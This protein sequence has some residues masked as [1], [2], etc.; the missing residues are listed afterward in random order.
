MGVVL[1]SNTA[2]STSPPTVALICDVG[3]G[4]GR[5]IIR[6]ATRFANLRRKWALRMDLLSRSMARALPECDGAIIAGDDQGKFEF[7][8]SR[9]KHVVRVSSVGDPSVCPIVT[10]DNAA[11]GRLA[12]EHLLGLGLNHYAYLGWDFDGLDHQRHTGFSERLA[13]SGFRDIA[14]TVPWGPWETTITHAHHPVMM[15]WIESLPKPVGL[16]AVDDL[17]AN[18]L[19]LACLKYEVA[20]PERVTIISIDDDTLLCESAWP[21]ISSVRCDFRRAGYEAA[22]LLERLI[23]GEELSESER[24]LKLPPMCVTERQS[25]DIAAIEDPSL[26]EALRYIRHHACDPC[27]VKDV[28]RYVPVSRRWLETQFQTH[29]SRSPH[30]EIA[31]VR[32][33]TGSRLLLQAEWSMDEIARR[34]GFASVQSFTKAF[35][36]ATGETPARYRRRRLQGSH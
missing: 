4:P 29:L 10:V 17:V 7:V 12:A 26:A 19:A 28:L 16:L 13:E 35:R 15:E 5:D 14:S 24:H 3:V 30:M 32:M 18:D 1:V 25:T 9:C 6:G 11:A 33:E 22:R 23:D 20:V 8:A 21:P 34:C 36:N 27:S 2:G 31:R